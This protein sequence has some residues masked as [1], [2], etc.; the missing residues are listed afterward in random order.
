M[1]YQWLGRLSHC[2]CI[3]SNL[4]IFIF[5][6]T[7]KILMLRFHRTVGKPA[8]AQRSHT[9]VTLVTNG[10]IIVNS[11]KLYLSLHRYGFANYSGCVNV[12]KGGARRNFQG[13][14]HSYILCQGVEE[15]KE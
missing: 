1:D 15:R 12:L 10:H 8:M 6:L 14:C 5:L 9:L 7:L 2:P 11:L 3:P 13:I 4:Y